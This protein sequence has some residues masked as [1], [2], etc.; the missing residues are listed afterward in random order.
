MQLATGQ[1][2]MWKITS[3]PSNYTTSG[4]R[5]FIPEP[6]HLDILRVDHALQARGVPPRRIHQLH[7]HTQ[8]TMVRRQVKRRVAH[9][10]CTREQHFS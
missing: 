3:V 6:S 2:S 1:P 10:K 5:P 9:L 4:N 7:R 8:H